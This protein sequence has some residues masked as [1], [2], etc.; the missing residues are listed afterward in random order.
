MCLEST[1]PL[2]T[3]NYL[4]WRA[5]LYTA[6]C[7]CYFDLKFPVRAEAFAN[8]GLAK[9]NEMSEIE[10]MSTSEKTAATDVAFCL[11]K[12]CSIDFQESGF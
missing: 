1:V 7:Q 6:V 8:R 9:V 4:R 12:I 5:T 11:A 3:V 2:L 10:K